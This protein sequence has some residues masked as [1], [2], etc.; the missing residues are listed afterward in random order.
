MFI[1]YYVL[2]TGLAF[3]YMFLILTMV[4]WG[5]GLWGWKIKAQGGKAT[6]P[7]SEY[8]SQGLTSWSHNSRASLETL[9]KVR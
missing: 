5:R 8:Q 4:L 9:E 7:T 2:C 6:H 3:L 1:V